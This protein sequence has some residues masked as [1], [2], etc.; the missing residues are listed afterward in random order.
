VNFLGTKYVVGVYRNTAHTAYTAHT[1]GNLYVIYVIC[2][3]FLNG[4][5]RDMYGIF[6]GKAHR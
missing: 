1:F 6:N 3:V 5:L 4:V 2:V